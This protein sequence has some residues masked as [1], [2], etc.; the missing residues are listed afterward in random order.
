ME[1]V[2]YQMDALVQWGRYVIM[3]L[4]AVLRGV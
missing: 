2:I 4:V 3:V 1:N